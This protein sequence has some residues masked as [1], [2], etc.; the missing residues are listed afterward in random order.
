MDINII[1][2]AVVCVTSGI[3]LG[4]IGQ[5]IIGKK[6]DEYINSYEHKVGDVGWYIA[7]FRPKVE[8]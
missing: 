5:S 4:Q 6:T 3:L 7:N 1:L 2:G 8:K